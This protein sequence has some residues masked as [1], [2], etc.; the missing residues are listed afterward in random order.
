MPDGGLHNNFWFIDLSAE[1]RLLEEPK[2]IQTQRVR[3]FG[4]WVLKRNR[5]DMLTEKEWLRPRCLSR[6]THHW[7]R[8]LKRHLRDIADLIENRLAKTGYVKVYL[9]PL[10]P[11]T[12][13]PKTKF[14]YRGQDIGCL[15]WIPKWAINVYEN[16]SYL[17]LD[18]S[19]HATKPFAYCVPQA[20]ICNEA[21]PLGLILTPR[22]SKVTYETFLTELWQLKPGM[23]RLPVLSD[24]GQGLIQFCKQYQ[25]EQFFCH[26]HIIEMFGAASTAGVLAARVLRIQPEEEFNALREQ[27]IA[28]A[29][30]LH[31]KGLMAQNSLDRF[32]RW[33]QNFSDGIWLRAP[34][35]IAR[36]SNHAERFHGVVN[37]SIRTKRARRFVGRLAV[38][39][40]SIDGKHADYGNGWKRQISS[41][42]QVLENRNLKERTECDDPECVAYRERMCIRYHVPQFPCPHTVKSYTAVSP[43]YPEI[44]DELNEQLVTT[45]L[46]CVDIETPKAVS[47]EQRKAFLPKKKSMALRRKAV[48]LWDDEMRPPSHVVEADASVPSYQIARNIVTCVFEMRARSRQLPPIDKIT[49]SFKILEHYC[50]AYSAESLKGTFSDPGATRRWL[51]EYGARWWKWALSGTECPA[52]EEGGIPVQPGH[53]AVL[54]VEPEEEEDLP[55]QPAQRPPAPRPSVI[56][57]FD[58]DGPII[59]WNTTHE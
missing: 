37:H 48:I 19:F 7:I 41:T 36:C 34:K 30:A 57:P 5:V 38:L 15:L 43:D 45:G 3:R 55:E 17:Q 23:Q 50:S 49:A 11:E 44:S 35:G 16:A 54:P 18:C 42:M 52:Q 8:D 14:H 12:G 27:F 4:K 20:M 6:S 25:I 46:I 31:A 59:L 28:D 9:N 10:N 32:T 13:T 51:A 2:L 56:D 33:I 40:N 39:L 1:F 29:E 22:E 58:E 26:R 24:K 53:E 21:V 47:E